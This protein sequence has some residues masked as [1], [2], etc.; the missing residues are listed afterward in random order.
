MEIQFTAIDIPIF[1]IYN[2]KKYVVFINNLSRNEI[3]LNFK[4]KLL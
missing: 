3:L 1:F 4:K 2:Y